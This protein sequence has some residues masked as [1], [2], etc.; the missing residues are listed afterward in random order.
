MSGKHFGESPGYRE[1]MRGSA[2]AVGD[3]ADRQFGD[4]RSVAGKDTEISVLAGDLRFLRRFV[5]HHFFR[6]DDFELESVCHFGRWSL[7]AGLRP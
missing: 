2:L 5:H 6:G 1:M 4:Q 3:F 7:V